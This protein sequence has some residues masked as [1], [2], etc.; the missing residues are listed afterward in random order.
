MKNYHDILQKTLDNGID[1]LN[2]RTK[3]VCKTLIGCQLEYD[4]S[5]K[6]PCLT[7]RKMFFN[8]QKGEVLSFFRGYDNAADFR[9]LGCNL[10][11]QNA[12]ETQSWL[13]NPARKG[14]DDCGRIYGVQWTR[15]SDKR[16]V[17]AKDIDSMKT[18]GYKLISYLYKEYAQTMVADA[19]MEREINQVENALRTILTN[20]SDRRIIVSGWNPAEM[21]LMCLPACHID[22]R[23]IPIEE[24]KELSVVMTIRSM[25]LFLGTPTNIVTTSLFLAIMARLSGYTPAKV[26]I[27]GT[28]AHLYDN[29]IEQTKEL[30]TREHL[31]LPTLKLSDNIKAVSVEEI[32]G[33]FERIQPEDIWLEGY[34]SHSKLSVS[35]IA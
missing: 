27:Q 31:S 28:N 9:A 2:T 1:I 21:D 8:G 15:W 26:I 24:T 14:E 29:S 17:K 10:W 6:F 22:Y 11:N 16:V 18:K 23:F 13:D 4:I 33:A 32:P 34:D 12:N 5:E 19:L 7:T 35:M 3:Q 20:P 30:L 25:D